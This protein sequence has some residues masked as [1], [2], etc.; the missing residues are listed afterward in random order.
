M[1]KNI[2]NDLSWFIKSMSDFI[3]DCGQ[4]NK[5]KEY[6]QENSE[7]DEFGIQLLEEEFDE[8]FG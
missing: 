6:L 4:W 3:S 2:S 5:F 8:I 7:I 1:N